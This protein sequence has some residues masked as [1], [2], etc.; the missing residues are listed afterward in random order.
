MQ[1][2]YNKWRNDPDLPCF[3]LG[4]KQFPLIDQIFERLM[5]NPHQVEEEEKSE[6]SIIIPAD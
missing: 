5:R 1:K 6:A 4:R 2:P 3:S